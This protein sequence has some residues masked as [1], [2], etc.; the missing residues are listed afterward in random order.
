M[1]KTDNEFIIVSYVK[2]TFSRY[3]LLLT[4]MRMCAHV[5]SRK[6]QITYFYKIIIGYSH[7]LKNKLY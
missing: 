1:I 2:L 5:E 6:K 3:S 4:N 7:F